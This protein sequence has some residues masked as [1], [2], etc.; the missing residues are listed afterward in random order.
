M[1]YRLLTR[2]K[3]TLYTYNVYLD[4]KDTLSAYKLHRLKDI[5]NVKFGVFR[6]V[7]TINSTESIL[8]QLTDFITG[9]LSYEANDTSKKNQAKVQIIDRIKKHKEI[10]IPC[11]NDSSNVFFIDLE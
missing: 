7:Q 2:K 10:L 4:I 11:V 8:L 9:A 6:N 3:D 1:Y 5:L